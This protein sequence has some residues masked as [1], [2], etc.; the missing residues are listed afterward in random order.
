MNLTN[1]YLLLIILSLKLS[2]SLHATES[3]T[4][5]EAEKYFNEQLYKKAKPLLEEEANKD[6]RASM[7]RLGFMYKNGLGV[8][9]D[10]KK[11]AY[12]FQKSAQEYEYTLNMKSKAEIEQK[13]FNERLKDQLNPDTNKKGE[14]YALSKLDT[15]TPETK[16]LILSN[17]KSD[18][19]GLKPHKTNFLL[20]MSYSSKKYGKISASNI[21]TPKT[22]YGSNTEVEFQ[23]SLKKLLT[24]NLFGWNEYITAAFTQKVWWQL[25]SDSGP[26]RE[27]NYLPEVFITIPSSQDLDDD[28]GLKAYKTGFVHESNGQEGYKSRSWNRIYLSGDFQFDN[29]FITPRIWYRIPEEKKNDDFYNGL[30]PNASGDDNPNIENYLG[31]GDLEINYLIAKHEFG[32]VLRYNFGSGGTNRGSIDVH[33]SY[34]FFNSKNT[35]WYLKFFNGYGESLIDYDKHVTKTAFGFSFSRGLF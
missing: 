13:P 34:P 1:K 18:F 10:D 9:Q 6:S 28:Y 32:S 19:F 2:I 16:E 20:P 27:T 5:L 8:K 17:L 12:W 3:Q 23:I 24:Y 30:K 31:Y 4:Y 11:A 7:Y 15:N 26:F 29:L 33:W 21:N 25:Y 14:E 35:F 22:Y